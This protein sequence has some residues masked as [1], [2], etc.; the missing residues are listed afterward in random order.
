MKAKFQGNTRYFQNINSA[1]KA[2]FIGF[3]AADGCIQQITTSSKGLS[4]TI[5]NKDRYVLDLLRECIGCEHK[6]YILKNNLVRFQLCNKDLVQDLKNLGLYERKTF[7]MGNISENIPEQFR[8]SFVLGFFDGD[9]SVILPVDCR[10]PNINTKRI[11]V[12]IR[13]TKP[14]LEGLTTSLSL[15]QFAIKKYDSTYRLDFS[16]KSEVLKFFHCYS[17]TPFFLIRKYQKFL[18]RL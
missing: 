18:V 2:Y 16:K 17:V 7:N 1:I 14:L 3:I 15:E 13:G 5:H 8:L 10:K 6:I 12:S 4:I 9:G 11:C